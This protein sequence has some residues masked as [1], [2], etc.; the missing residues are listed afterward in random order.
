MDHGRIAAHGAY[1]ELM[2]SKTMFRA[3][4]RQAG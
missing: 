2:S 3:M 1:D 4:A